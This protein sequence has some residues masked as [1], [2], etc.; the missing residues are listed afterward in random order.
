[1]E[2]VQKYMKVTKRFRNACE[3]HQF[4]KACEILSGLQKFRKGAKLI[5]HSLAFC[6]T[7]CTLLGQFDACEY[8][9]KGCKIVEC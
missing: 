5:L 9:S 6:P 4:R 8:F 1:M 3:N 2:S 7:T